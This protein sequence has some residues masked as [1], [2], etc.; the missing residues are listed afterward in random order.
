MGAKSRLWCLTLFEHMDCSPAGSSVHEI[1]QARISE[2]V[3]FSPPGDLPGSGIESESLVLPSGF[4]TPESG[5]EQHS[6][7]IQ[8]NCSL[9]SITRSENFNVGLGVLL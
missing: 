1:S 3:S 9:M 6:P 5:L 4:F 2:W 7:S 8:F